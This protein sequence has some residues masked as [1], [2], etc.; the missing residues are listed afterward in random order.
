MNLR[1]SSYP[2]ES[3]KTEIVEVLNLS[4]EK[5]GQI[6][7][8]GAWRRYCFYPDES[9]LFDSSCLAEIQG[10]IHILMNNRGVVSYDK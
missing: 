6:K 8:Y 4:M 1:F 2:S 7:W 10:K 3:G 5:L 9:T